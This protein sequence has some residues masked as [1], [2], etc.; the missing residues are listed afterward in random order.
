[1]PW[2]SSS[3]DSSTRVSSSAS[4]WLLEK[5]EALGGSDAVR[6]VSV[7]KCCEQCKGQH[8]VWKVRH[9]VVSAGKVVSCRDGPL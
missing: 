8:T 3:R 6:E 5:P 1:M 4:S 2:P 9:G 7:Q